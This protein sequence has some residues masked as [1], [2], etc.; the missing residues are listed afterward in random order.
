[1][2]DMFP[3]L[4]AGHILIYFSHVQGGYTALMW[5]AREGN[6]AIVQYLVERT[7]AQVNATSNVSHSNSVRIGK[8]HGF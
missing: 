1:M 2:R 3:F 8:T 4:I 5:G 7:T 6:T